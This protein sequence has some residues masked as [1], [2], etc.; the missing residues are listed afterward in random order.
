MTDPHAY[1][2]RNELARR[3]REIASLMRA[4][5]QSQRAIA[6]SLRQWARYAG[7]RTAVITSDLPINVR[8]DLDRLVTI[9]EST[10]S[11]LARAVER[12][13]SLAKAIRERRK[14]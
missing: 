13:D 8:N 1:L 4:L 11:H 14:K 9:H 10:R 3:D 12:R 2:D 7:G 6:T 5:K